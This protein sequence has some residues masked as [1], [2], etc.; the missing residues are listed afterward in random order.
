MVYQGP[1]DLFTAEYRTLD[2]HQ[3][4]HIFAV[5]LLFAAFDA[6]GIGSNDVANAFATAVGARS[7]T[8]RMACLIALVTEFIGAISLGAE[9]AD[10]IKGKI[11]SQHDF[12][13]QSDMLMLGMFCSSI[14][15]SVWVN[16]ASYIGMPV[17]TTHATVGSTIGVGI[18]FGGKDTVTWGGC[19]GSTVNDCNG[20]LKI[21]CSWFIS[22]ALAAAFGGFVFMIT[23]LTVLA[24]GGEESYQRA[25]YCMPVYIGVVW[26]VVTFF[27][28][29]KGGPAL[30]SE[31]D[32]YSKNDTGGKELNPSAIGPLFGIAFGVGCFFGLLSIPVFLMNPR[33]ES[34]CR[35]THAEEVEEA[36]KAREKKAAEEDPSSMSNVLS[37]LVFAGMDKEVVEIT[38]GAVGANQARHAQEAAEKYFEPT[39]RSFQFVQVFT[40]SFSSLSHGANDVANAIGPFCT[41]YHVWAT[42][43]TELS[44]P[45]KSKK[46]PVPAWILAFGGIFI[47]LGLSIDGWR[48]MRNLGNNITYQSPSRGAAMELGALTT[49]LIASQQGI[50]VSTTHCMTGA[51]VGVGMCNG[52]M[53]SINW[54]MVA[55]ASFGWVITLPCAGLVAGL[56]FAFVGKAPKLLSETDQTAILTFKPDALAHLN[57]PADHKM[58][59]MCYV[60]SSC[61]KVRFIKSFRDSVFDF[62]RDYTMPADDSDFV[63]NGRY[64]WAYNETKVYKP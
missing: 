25:R 36:A 33:F 30:N 37:K 20:V 45:S 13:G 22:P 40:A 50:P 28:A 5:G 64:S 43:F 4:V 10:T 17:S 24:P 55:W 35:K 8:L 18:A 9:V 29:L 54:L 62:Q 57:V 63:K 6:Y 46:V 19:T 21:V 41:V 53:G 27:M 16:S 58:N 38:D 7:L 2:K 26:S 59:G 14:G 48:L 12:K 1:D 56:I 23:K 39:E 51:T 60:Q 42:G 52:D 49:V 32:L 61:N 47:D 11:I 31:F 15:S 44:D 34:Y 3:Y